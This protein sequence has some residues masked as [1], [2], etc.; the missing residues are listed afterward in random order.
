MNK[1]PYK[2]RLWIGVGLILWSIVAFLATIIYGSYGA[3]SWILIAGPIFAVIAFA[4]G[5][6]FIPKTNQDGSP[7]VVESKPKQKK[8]HRRNSKKQKEPFISDKER[9]G[10]EDEEDDMIFIDE[11]VEDD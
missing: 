9:K 3:P 6:V 10:F 11:V 5:I 7:I 4:I 1:I 2:V 8:Q